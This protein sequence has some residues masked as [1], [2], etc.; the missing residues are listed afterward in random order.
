[1]NFDNR[2]LF[3]HSPIRLGYDNLV[4]DTTKKGRTYVTPEGNKYPSIT[5]VLG[6]LSKEAIIAWRKRVG[7]EEANRISRHAAHRGTQL[8][9]IAERYINNEEKVFADNEMP[10]VKALFKAVR[11]L[12]DK[13]IGKIILQE[14][15]LYSD[16]LQV[17]GRVDLIAEYKGILSVI[18]FKTSKRRKSREDISSYFMQ[19]AFYA[20][21]FYERTGIPI[22]QS[23]IL[24]GV[25]DDPVPLEFEESTFEWLPELLKVI[26][27]YNTQK[28]FGHA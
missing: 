26:K 9:T 17:A 21:A 16:K 27:T 18:D 24:M 5:T 28:L 2:P 7:E 10:H 8:H 20:A 1:M 22:K 25:D 6:S 15:P 14:T 4:D 13:Y 3:E 11:P 12:I 19:A 23:V